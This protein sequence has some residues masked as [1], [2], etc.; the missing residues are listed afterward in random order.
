MEVC[1]R[2]AP[3]FSFLFLIVLVGCQP[4][5]VQQAMREVSTDRLMSHIAVLADDSLEGRRP[6]SRGE[7]RTINYLVDQYKAIGLEPA[8][9]NGTYLQ[10]VPTVGTQIDQ[11]TVFE[12][13][14]GGKSLS[15]KFFDDFI[16]LSGYH[17]PLVPIKDVELVFVGYGIV[18]PEQGWDDY[19]DVDVKG[20]VLLMLNNDPATDDPNFFAGRGRTYY[21][22]W[23]YKYEIAAQKGAVGAIILHTTESAGYPFSVV[24]STWSAERYDLAADNGAPKLKLKSWT[25]EDATRKYVSL[26]GFDLDKLVQQAQEKGFR[27]VPLGVKISTTLKFRIRH[28]ET[29]NVIGVLRGSD[30]A[31][32]QEHI[33]FTSHWDHF[34]IGK[35]VNGDSIYNG[36]LDNASGMSLM[37]TMAKAFSTMNLKRSLMFAAVTAEEFGLLG[38][39]YLAENPPIPIKHVVANINTDGMNI[40]G[41]TTDITFLGQERSTLGAD[42][43]E[44]AKIMK[45]EIKPDPQPEQG[46]FYRSDHFNFAK[47]GVPCLSMRTGTAFVG[48]PE[49]FAKEIMEQYIALHYHKPSDQ[50]AADWNL[51]GGVQQAEF[52]IRL[53]QRI[54]NSASAPQWNAGDE[55]AKFR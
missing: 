26:A 40:W 6:A 45:M 31:L 8:G 17:E 52:I 3:I 39:Q 33:V 30:P 35:P 13:K 1:M 28:L 7:A 51:E 10:K 15:L 5:D 38:S 11:K 41:T 20:K 55:F 24:Q 44:V 23:T 9:E 29:Q 25:T 42:I 48:K 16:A 49:T 21:G 4:D 54:A 19:K 37:L 12:F 53:T 14:K 18:A 27:P 34:G 50:I 43:E 2:F 32:N 47:V 36:A 46:S 22:R